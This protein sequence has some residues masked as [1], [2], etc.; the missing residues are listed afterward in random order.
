MGLST[1]AI[2]VLPTY[3]QIG[4]LAPLLLALCRFGQGLGL[5]GEWG[6]A[7]LLATENAPPG[8]RAWYGMFPQLGAPLG[9]ICSGGVFLLLS[10]TLSDAQ[11]FNFGWRIP[12]LASSLLVFMGLYVRLRIQET[13]A[14]QKAIEQQERVRM[15]MMSVLRD[16]PKALVLGTMMSVATFGLFYLMTVFT[17]SWGTNA[18][19]YPRQQFL[20]ILLFGIQIGRAHVCTPVTNTQL[21]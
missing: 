3:A 18:L 12:F 7:V 19:G 21:V 17:L 8:K 6:G 4:T 2:G 5:G 10:E 16:H 14:F 20:L 9:F 13:P 15:P 1:V 11:F